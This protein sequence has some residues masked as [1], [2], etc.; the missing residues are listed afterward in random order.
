VTARCKPRNAV[1]HPNT[2]ILGL[3]PTRGLDI[4]VRLFCVVCVLVAALQW[5]D[6]PS[7]ESYPLCIAEKTAKAQQW[8]VEPLIISNNII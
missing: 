6:P 3:N 2:G 5:A 4:Y 1:A 7:K 8:A